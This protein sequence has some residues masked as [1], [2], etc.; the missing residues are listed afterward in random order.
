[1]KEPNFEELYNKTLKKLRDYCQHDQGIRHVAGESTCKVCGW[2]MHI[3]DHKP[4]K[5]LGHI[6]CADC[7]EKL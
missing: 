1:M 4:S 3:C 2:N 7:G 5:K 6:Y